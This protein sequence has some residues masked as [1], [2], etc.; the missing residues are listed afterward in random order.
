MLWVL[1]AVAAAALQAARNAFS[2]RLVGE[3]SPALTAWSR[4]A[5]NLPFSAALALGLA[6]AHGAPALT[7]G[8]FGWALAGAA[9]QLVANFALVAAFRVASFSQSVALHK[10]EVV[11]GAGVG[12]AFFGEVPSAL[13]W[14]GILLSTLGVLLMNLAR[15]D[16]RGVGWKRMFHLDRGSLY[17]IACGALFAF[18][19]F[20]FKEAI[21]L[22]GAANPRMAGGRFEPAV[23][24]VFHVAWMQVALA[25]PAVAWMRPGELRRTLSLWPT[26]LG[27]GVTGFLGSLCWFWAF[28]LTLVAYVRAVGQIEAPISV[29]ISLLVFRERG[30][31]RQLPAIAAIVGGVVLVL[32]G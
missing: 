5:F 13:G 10:L 22:L 26:M 2:R 21:L 9:T 23:H 3:V 27:I 12:L 6:A 29:A 16:E 17:A 7:A 14:L 24:T 25:T 31:A 30:V 19:A 15:P 18:T 11:F 4:F 32:L 1:L 8:F 28:G 20:F